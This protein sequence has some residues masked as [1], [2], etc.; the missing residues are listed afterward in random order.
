MIRKV[1]L[2]ILICLAFV[3]CNGSGAS[4]QKC[5][6]DSNIN[7]LDGQG[8]IYMVDTWN[9][10]E[11]LDST[12][13][14]NGVFRY[15]VDAKQPTM[16]MLRTEYENI[17]KTGFINDSGFI[18]LQGNVNEIAKM[19]VQGTPMNDILVELKKKMEECFIEPSMIKRMELC[20]ELF[21]AKL[22]ENS[23][24]AC[25]IVMVEMSLSG[26][27]PTVL[28]GYMDKLEPYLK[29]KAYVRKLKGKL[30]RLEKVSPYIEGSG[31]APCYIDMEYP[32]VTGDMIKLSDVIANPK[33]KYVY[34]D[35][36]STWC[37]PCVAYLQS[38]KNTY[39]LYKDM[40]F[41]VYAVSCDSNVEGWKQFVAEE[42]AGWIDVVA[43]ASFPQWKA[44]EIDGIPTS[45]LIDCP[46]GMIVGRDLFGDMLNAKLD[47]LL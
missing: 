22:D 6:I 27:H 17:L 38:L 33:N 19:P 35:F 5:V 41:E 25:S 13:F 39:K 4:E 23:G 32:G 8:W 47:E 29:D 24:N 28:L 14:N 2:W 44:Y 12:Q 1:T 21:S 15:E 20:T 43:G 16:V 36:W 45:F 18:S 40:G 30:E 26:I 11:V 7:G 9:G 10:N 42:N 37:A 46:T 3:A 31:I 34:I